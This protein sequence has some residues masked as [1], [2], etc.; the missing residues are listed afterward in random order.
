MSLGPKAGGLNIKAPKNWP[1]QANRIKSNRINISDFDGRKPKQRRQSTTWKRTVCD[2]RRRASR[3][4]W[5]CR[6]TG[7]RPACS[8]LS[9][10]PKGQSHTFQGNVVIKCHA[11]F[12]SSSWSA[13][14]MYNIVSNKYCQSI[15]VVFAELAFFSKSCLF[16]S[17][18]V[19]LWSQL[20]SYFIFGK[21]LNQK[22]ALR[23]SCYSR[24]FVFI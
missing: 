11:I 4:G 10:G 18:T 1:E 24:L 7:S 3:S 13:A 12:M 22:I 19:Y 9:P 21:I 8:S 23:S 20:V 17:I 6:D 2:D 5:S 14:A 15:G 16:I